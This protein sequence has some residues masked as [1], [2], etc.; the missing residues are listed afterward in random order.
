MFLSL[1]IISA[2][3]LKTAIALKAALIGHAVAH[4][5]ATTA[6][7]HGV[8]A[9]TTTAAAHGVAATTA[10][11]TAAHGVAT[12]TAAYGV[13]ATTAHGAAVSNLQQDLAALSIVMV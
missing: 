6:A 9:A 11:T 3:L 7:A 12:T 10:A 8:A 4:G 2:L 5:V 13:A 1:S